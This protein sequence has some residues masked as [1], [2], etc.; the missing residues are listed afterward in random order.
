ATEKIHQLRDVR[1]QPNPASGLAQMLHANAAELRVMPNQVRELPVLLHQIA[2]GEPGALLVKPGHA[3]QVGQHAARVVEAQGLVEV[4]GEEEMLGR[5]N[6]AGRHW[7]SGKVLTDKCE[8]RNRN[9]C[10]SRYNKLLGNSS[11][12]LQSGQVVIQ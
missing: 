4:R 3:E 2:L 10:I 9:E 6:G 7:A 11:A 5:I 1:A 8:G 12:S